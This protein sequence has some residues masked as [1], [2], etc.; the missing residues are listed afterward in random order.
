MLLLASLLN[1]SLDTPP[2]KRL[3]NP[4]L[5][6]EQV[7]L[8]VINYTAALIDVDLKWVKTFKNYNLKKTHA[9]LWIKNIYCKNLI[10]AWFENKKHVELVI[11]DHWNKPGLL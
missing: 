9:N 7:L 5:A 2:H 3:L 8:K 10:H 4:C 11:S 1:S 6:R